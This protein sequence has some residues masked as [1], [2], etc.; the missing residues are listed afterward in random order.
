MFVC[1]AL[2]FYKLKIVYAYTTLD[3]SRMRTCTLSKIWESFMVND[4][5]SLRFTKLS[6]DSVFT[7]LGSLQC[8]K[9]MWTP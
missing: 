6:A 8:E 7:V 5:L 9:N 4:P 2:H 3:W 1:P